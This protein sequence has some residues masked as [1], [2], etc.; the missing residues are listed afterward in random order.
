MDC[1]LTEEDDITGLYDWLVDIAFEELFVVA[2]EHVFSWG[3]VNLVTTFDDTEATITC[4]LIS[5]K[6]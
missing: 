2:M 3:E 5:Q 6:E 1:G 4:L